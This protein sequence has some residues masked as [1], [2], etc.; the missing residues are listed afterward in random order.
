MNYLNDDKS[1]NLYVLTLLIEYPSGG[2]M[3]LAA[4][5]RWLSTEKQL[6]E[7]AAECHKVYT[8]EGY[9]IRERLLTLVNTEANN[10]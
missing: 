2:N 8:Q 6:T 10:D 5:Q 7:W 4:D 3:F 1:E 9:K